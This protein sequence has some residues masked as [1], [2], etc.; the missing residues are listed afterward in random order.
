[1][2]YVPNYTDNQ[3]AVI[4]DK[5]T[6][7]VYDNIPTL[8]QNVSYTDYFIHSDYMSK[9]GTELINESSYIQCESDVSD[10]Y[11]YR[12]DFV[13]IMLI[14]FILAYIIIYVP[15]RIVRRMFGRWLTV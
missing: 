14:F 3:C 10:S 12:I 1:M 7:R 8:N 13:N 2:I 6:I 15:Y 5:D 4:H 11:Y 9:K